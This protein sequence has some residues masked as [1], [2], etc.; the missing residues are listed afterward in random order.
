MP[1]LD[2]LLRAVQE[3]LQVHVR[4]LTGDVSLS[5]DVMQTVL[6]T[7]ARS[8]SQLRDPR[9][10]RAWAYRIATRV[11]CR[12]AKNERRWKDALREDALATLPAVQDDDAAVDPEDLSDLLHHLEGIGGASGVV[13][14]MHYADGL[15][16]QEIAEALEVPLGTVKSRLAYGLSAL[17]RMVQPLGR[18]DS[19]K[20]T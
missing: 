6:W 15:T 16:Y 9:W 2:K 8:V 18:F 1:S 7:I 19:I 5:E 4:S 10:F 20:R 14:R 3:P 17:R 13:L 11:A 12:A